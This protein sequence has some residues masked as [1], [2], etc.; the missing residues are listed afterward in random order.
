M[1]FTWWPRGVTLGMR[2]TCVQHLLHDI[3][4]LCML[5]AGVKEELIYKKVFW[6]TTVL[7][8]AA[9]ART[10]GRAAQRLA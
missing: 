10:I 3:P 6:Q 2:G 8:T 5:A 9:P 7:V 4:A 1:D